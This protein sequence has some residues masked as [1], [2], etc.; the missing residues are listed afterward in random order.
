VMM[1]VGLHIVLV[2]H[3]SPV[4]PIEVE[5]RDEQAD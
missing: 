1:M 5:A 4:K 2:R 3:D